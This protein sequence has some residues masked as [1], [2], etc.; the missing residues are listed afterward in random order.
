MDTQIHL[1]TPGCLPSGNFHAAGTG[2]GSQMQPSKAL[3]WEHRWAREAQQ[4]ICVEQGIDE[5]ELLRQKELL[6]VPYEPIESLSLITHRWNS[7]RLGRNNFW[8]KN[9]YWRPMHWVGLDAMIF[10]FWMLSFKP[11]FSLSSFTFIKRLFSS[12]SLSA[13]RVV[14]SEYLR[15]LIFLQAIL[16][17][18]C[19]SS[20]PAFLRMYAAY[21]L[22]KHGDNIQPWCTPFHIW[23]QSVVP[24]SVLTVASYR[25]L[26]RQVQWSGIPI[27]FIIFQFVLIHTVKGFDIVNKLE[28]DVFL[29]LLLFPL[30]ADVGNLISG[31]SQFTYCWSL[32]WRI[33]NITLLACKMSVIVW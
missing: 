29:E 19:A 16:I 30:P 12:S 23:N 22:N 5:R 27:S 33:L 2:R 14:S 24:C 21:K 4:V 32:A 26:K 1:K 7:T 11:T 3:I 28:I 6:Q 13:I 9:Y 15:L 8:G 18:A 10:V 25:F 17:P 31:S 20:S